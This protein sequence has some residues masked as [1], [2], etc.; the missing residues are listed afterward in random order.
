LT[1]TINK[2]KKFFYILSDL[3]ININ[4]NNTSSQKINFLNATESNGA[5]HSI[6]KPT[7]VTDSS[8]TV[9]DHIITNDVVHKLH[10]SVILCDL[11][12]HY[13]IMCIIDKLETV[14]FNNHVPMYR[15]R[16]KT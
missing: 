3:N 12:D 15:D 5:F 14:N 16:K 2:P 7:R 6:T 10:P 13:S 9:I 1:R 11:T 4:E 8:S